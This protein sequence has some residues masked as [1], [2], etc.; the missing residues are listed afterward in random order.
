MPR[1]QFEC[2][3]G[4]SFEFDVPMAKR[5]DPIP[6]ANDEC[7]QQARMVIA[8]TSPGGMLDHG[9]ARNRDMAREGRWDP[10]NPNRRFMVKGRRWRK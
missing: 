3:H 4:H 10:E 9:S 6:C 8:H 1:Y 7:D 5:L 2:P